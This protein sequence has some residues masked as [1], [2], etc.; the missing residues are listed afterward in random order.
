M[1]T[2]ISASQSTMIWIRFFISASFLLR[3]DDWYSGLSSSLVMTT[4]I[5]SFSRNSFTYFAISRLISFSN[6]WFIPT[7]PESS[8]PCPAS[9]STV[10][11]F[12]G[13]VDTC[14]IFFVVAAG[15]TYAS[16]RIKSI[17]INF[18]V[19]FTLTSYFIILFS[20]IFTLPIYLSIFCSAS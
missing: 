13:T 17:I 20:S 18:A 15:I 4:L 16:E 12:F 3:S 5:P 11:V 2:A 6:T 14:C 8:A 9:R 19:C 10:N 1:L 7:L